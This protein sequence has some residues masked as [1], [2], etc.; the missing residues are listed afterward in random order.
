[1]NRQ[2]IIS[3]DFKYV[4]RATRNFVALGWR[5]VKSKKWSDGKYTYV[6]EF[7]DG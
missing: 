4:T 3:G 7:V 1:M 2:K 6:M 5:I